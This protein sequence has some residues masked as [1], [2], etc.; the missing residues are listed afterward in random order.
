MVIL[1]HGGPRER[2]ATASLTQQKLKRLRWLRSLNE[3]DRSHNHLQD[4]EYMA[5]K[6]RKELDD[7]VVDVSKKI[8]RIPIWVSDAFAT[9]KLKLL[10]A[11]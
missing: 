7:V 1:I 6:W 8:P 4:V 3:V 2:E 11:D 9:L 5:K 10:G